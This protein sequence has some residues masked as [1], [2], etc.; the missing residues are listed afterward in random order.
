M[1]SLSASTVS[2]TASAADMTTALPEKTPPWNSGPRAIRSMVA[3]SE[4][5]VERRPT[6]ELPHAL[7]LDARQRVRLERALDERHV[8]QIQGQALGAEHVLNHRQ[9]LAAAAHPFLDVVVKPPL[10]EL[11]IRK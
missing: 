11:H 2:R 3:T 5:V 4:A 7:G 10:K 6:H 8:R 9:V 1:F